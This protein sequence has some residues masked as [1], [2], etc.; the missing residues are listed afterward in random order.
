MNAQM[1]GGKSSSTNMSGFMSNV[2]SA[3]T[4]ATASAGS[5]FSSTTQR[6]SEEEFLAVAMAQNAD[7]FWDHMAETRD[8][9]AKLEEESEESWSELGLAGLN[10]IPKFRPAYYGTKNTSNAGS[11]PAHIASVSSICSGASE[12]NA[13]QKR[14]SDFNVSLQELQMSLP[15]PNLSSTSRSTQGN[16]G[17]SNIQFYDLNLTRRALENW[18]LPQ[19]CDE[20]V[21]NWH[22]QCLLS[23]PERYL[24]AAFQKS[25]CSVDE[26]LHVVENK[27]FGVKDTSLAKGSAC[28]KDSSDKKHEKKGKKKNAKGR[29]KKAGR[30]SHLSSDNKETNSPAETSSKS[31]QKPFE[32]YLLFDFVLDSFLNQ[33]GQ[34]MSNQASTSSLQSSSTTWEVQSS[35]GASTAVSFRQHAPFSGDRTPEA[36]KDIEAKKT[37][38]LKA[39]AKAPVNSKHGILDKVFETQQKKLIK[40][41]RG[42]VEATEVVP[43]ESEV[44]GKTPSEVPTA[45]AAETKAQSNSSSLKKIGCISWDGQKLKLTNYFTVLAPRNFT[46]GHSG[47]EKRSEETRPIEQHAH[48]SNKQIK[49][50]NLAK[51]KFGDGLTSAVCVFT[52]KA[53]GNLTPLSEESKNPHSFS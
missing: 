27:R 38:L 20:F 17:G 29:G 23:L 25:V 49:S 43:K 30:V 13:E 26:L 32:Y 18:D 8:Y 41:N 10:E 15:H 6:N 39:K 7:K 33:N 12:T 35:G 21:Q 4:Q 37:E 48:P 24:S 36:K 5:G 3:P 9:L 46:G 1:K 11:V 42:S 53:T 14:K 47:S 19:A 45:G 51:G 34:A 28:S 22:D 40:S 44:E 16:A 31:T 2:S 52:S 50:S